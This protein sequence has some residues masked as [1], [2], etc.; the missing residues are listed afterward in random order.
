MS[1]SGVGPT[2]PFLTVEDER[3][4]AIGVRTRRWLLCALLILVPGCS[5]A[6]SLDDAGDVRTIAFLHSVRTPTSPATSVFKEELARN[7][8]V[9]SRNL[10]ILGEGDGEVYPEPEEAAAAVRR[11]RDRGAEV[12]VAYSTAAARIAAET[13]PGVDVLFLSNDPTAAGL[14]KDE[15]RPEGSMT[16]VTFRVPADRT[17][18]LARRIM[19]E[20]RRVG[21][22]FPPS[23]PAAIPSKDNFAAEASRQGLELITEEFS[24]ESD[25]ERAVLALGDQQVQVLL[26][27]ISPTATRAL[28][29]FAEAANAIGVPVVANIDASEVALFSLRPDSDALNRQLARQA[30]RLLNGASPQALPVEDPRR[31]LLTLN[32][33]V[34]ARHGID[35][36]ADV[37]REA[38]HVLP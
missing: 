16:G 10:R 34:A 38:D 1:T 26:L 33:G 6:Q 29:Q 24:D 21:L 31:F 3:V 15:D 27:S 9:E 18:M 14:V 28:A 35:L 30:T 23:D 17:L 22:A 8:F 5:N 13:A 7:G 11:W 37:V 25:V 4:S 32:Q 2:P 12:I 20:L 36:P 19:P